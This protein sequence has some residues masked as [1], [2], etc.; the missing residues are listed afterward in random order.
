[1]PSDDKELLY[2]EQDVA[3][4]PSVVGNFIKLGLAATLGFTAYH[5]GL[6]RPIIEEM[7]S[8]AD[9][10]AAEGTNKAGTAM[11]TIKEWTK[12][13]H[14]T[15]AQIRNL[16]KDLPIIPE[17]SIFRVKPTDFLYDVVED[18][19]KM[20]SSGNVDYY[21]VKK[22]LA[23]SLDDLNILHSMIDKNVG[24]IVKA[25]NSFVDT[26]L[27]S[28]IREY[29]RFSDIATYAYRDYRGAAF[30][31]RRKYADEFVDAL[32]L[33]D[34]AAK[35]E[36]FH[37]GFHRARLK[38]FLTFDEAE[39]RLKLKTP[40]GHFSGM[41]DYDYKTGTIAIDKL[42]KFFDEGMNRYH[43]KT[44]WQSGAWE[45]LVLDPAIQISESGRVIDY[46][47]TKKQGIDFIHSLSGDFGLP[48][49]KFNLLKML[50]ADKAFRHKPFGAV[51]APGQ[52][53]PSFTGRAGEYSVG[54]FMG[55][56]LGDEYSKMAVSVI[57]GKAY[58]P[59]KNK[60]GH[61]VLQEFEGKF[62]LH[63]VTHADT[64]MHLENVVNAE[65]QMANLHLA[66][67]AR[68]P[69]EEY[70]KV[71][72]EAGVPENKLTEYKIR[73]KIGDLLDI[74][75]QEMFKKQEFGDAAFRM[76][77]VNP[78][79]FIDDMIAKV[80][81]SKL[82]QTTGFEYGSYDSMM[83][84]ISAGI[85]HKSILGQGFS[86]FKTGDNTIN[87]GMY[88]MSRKGLTIADI[89]EA[90]NDDGLEKGSEKIGDYVAQFFAGRDLVNPGYMTK[91]FNEKST[92]LWG[93]LNK[94]SE[95]IGASSHLLGL[96]VESKGSV[97]QLLGNLLLKRALP[98]Y[99]AFQIPGM[100]NWASE[101]FFGTDENGNPRN[102]GQA[103][104]GGPVKSFDLMAHK[105][106][107]LTM[108]T[109]VFKELGK[110]TP[111][112]DQLNEDIPFIYAM[113]LGQTEEERREYIEKGYDPVRKGRFWGTG[114]TPW[115][116]GKIMYW[117]PNIYRRVE[118]DVQFSDS[119]WGSRQ[120]YYNNAWFPNPVN[121]F[122]PIRHFI[123]DRYHYEEKHYQD[124]PYMITSPEGEN[125]PVIGP[126]FAQTIGRVIKPPRRMH[127]EYW[128]N[129]VVNPADEAPSQLIT[130]TDVPY[131]EPVTPG[132]SLEYVAEMFRRQQESSQ[133][134]V[135]I[136]Q[137]AATTW[138][139]LTNRQIKAQQRYKD[140]LYTSAY[141]AREMVSK[142]TVM[143]DAGVEYTKRTF[144]P[145][146]DYD[147]YGHPYEAYV[148]PSGGISIVDVP[149]EMNIY[150]INKDLR[151]WSINR[152]MGTDQRVDVI[153]EYNNPDLPV[154]N[155]SPQIDNA[156]ITGMGEE[157]NALTD[158]AGLRGFGVRQFITGS[159]NENA[160]I[161][162][163]SG[164]A[165]SAKR[166]FWD[167][168]LGG[169]GGNISEISRRFMQK[170]NN[171]IDYINPVRNTMPS[172]MPG[173]DYFV[174]DFLHGD[175]YAKVE[176]GE[177]RLPGEGYERMYNLENRFKMNIGSSSIGYSKEDIIKHLLG[178]EGYMSGF[179][180]DTLETGTEIHEQ[181]EKLWKDTGFAVSTE[182][183][184]VDNDNGIIGYYDALVHDRSSKT[185]LAIV[186]IKTTSAKKLDEIRK[187]GKPL[188]HHMRQVNYYLWA[189]RN[190]ES[191]GY[192]YYVDKEN[193]ENNYMVGF[194]YSQARLKDT[195]KNVKDARDEIRDAMSRGEI[196]RGDL[197]R[198]IDRLRILADVA[199]Y[200]QEFRDAKA[201]L[202]Q[203]QI[204]QATRD[205]MSAINKRVTEQKEP[206]RVYDYKFSTSNLTTEVVTVKEVIDNDM[207]KTVEY[208]DKHSVQ[209]AG[210]RPSKAKG[211]YYKDTDKTMWQ[212]TNDEIR[213]YIKPGSKIVIQYDADERNKFKKNST[214]SIN[215]VIS[216]RG[217]NVNRRLLEKGMA[218]EK[219]TDNS[220]AGVHV[221]YTNGEIAF[222]AA[223]ERL[224]HLAGRTPFINKIIQVR[225]P[226]EQ[227]KNKEVYGKD[228]QSWNNPIT[229]ILIPTIEKDIGNEGLGGV[230][231]LMLGTYMGSLFGRNKFG[232]IIGGATGFSLV[233]TGKVLKTLG[234]TEE[235]NWVPRRRRKQ[236]ELNEYLDAL[237]YVKNIR[238][239]GEYSNKAKQEDNFDVESYIAGKE[240]KGERNKE[241]IRELEDYK[242]I[243]KLDF[244]HRGR[245][246]FD[247]GAP[248]YATRDMGYKDTIYNINK[249]IREL[250][251]DRKIE[252]LPL[253]AIKAIQF[254]QEAEKTMYGF[255]P[256]DSL[257]NIMSAL[258][259][260][261]RQY[262]K[263]FM[264]APEEEKDKILRI[265]PSYLRRALQAS[266]GL[267]VD[268]KPDLATYFTQHALPGAD[269]V[270][271]NEETDMDALKVKL[272]HASKLD[273]G[274]FDIWQNNK[275]AADQVNI[276]IPNINATHTRQE[277][278][279]KLNSLFKNSG[280]TDV[281]FR[282]VM[283]GRPST[284]ID[285]DEDAR[286]DVEYQIQNLNLG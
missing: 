274:E 131:T 94:L 162:E 197:Y 263:H 175:P 118:A 114:G 261:E 252:K 245:Y 262:F 205:E 119:K 30:N 221:R 22:V 211:E 26:D 43:G 247:Y 246:N 99:M 276:P 181:I 251:N 215:A 199:P 237:K 18:T 53:A 116:G 49:V 127:M 16:K 135:A 210:I 125:I 258:P 242:R 230:A 14:M 11:T 208:G 191:K 212:A 112:S 24:N 170:R 96:S 173:N 280:F 3:G 267:T 225:S 93:V 275:Q 213:K 228:F 42:N 232:R 286:D 227:Y 217:V 90:I 206:L 239:Y 105:I 44:F 86:E 222:G 117:R 277:V 106:M 231:G 15:A 202:A 10:I 188:E 264:D 236:E 250:Q 79:S 150:N 177:E 186:D 279:Y 70:K 59:V 69:W 273:P 235:R 249:E 17:R 284:I 80:T 283:N 224:T 33:T 189:T 128:A 72:L 39:G 78:D 71:L 102:V 178:Q 92:Y 152:V 233:A 32:S 27:F 107:D 50:G 254:K 51:I 214:Q 104:M 259:K 278:Y 253:N 220:P 121:P 146:R 63:D 62:N 20:I 91:N 97:G 130:G 134:Q 155:D 281:Q 241:R 164:Y 209:F 172:W 67:P 5:Q 265:A 48:A 219:E 260:K 75:H 269:W 256:G 176:N 167:Q 218:T 25:R 184:I 74:G 73:Y 28:R 8:V 268:E 132:I 244:S 223:M 139:E 229:G 95:G 68:M 115:S 82:L 41:Q 55:D 120:E 9:K 243:V 124:R 194:D 45:N 180:E 60:A 148:T 282:S 21:N 126:A 136:R 204:D 2:D 110:L 84:S 158:V 144:L 207:I 285:L 257:V 76:D 98:V 138:E 89:F 109:S 77:D 234:T 122:A 103:L 161:I 141:Q 166:S 65:R 169:L 145:Q 159:M 185:G 66:Q 272:V 88:Y 12:L 174:Q 226:Y 101:P 153:N 108:V 240:G 40:D 183:K 238:L 31:L 129:P 7:F 38:D 203:S 151:R 64:F 133:E 198:P 36:Q 156:F 143:D 149:D 140:V 56:M 46:R 147:R 113:G 160:S 6:L 57:G 216:S 201:E 58:A 23:D 61:Y 100:I 248:K 200:S 142:K 52:F 182:G 1:M 196:S 179:E 34:E 13:K 187:S 37:T 271:W 165:Y 111:G 87:P 83:D 54:Q 193:L 190:T 168:N 47:M 154:G 171:N 123:T 4:G 266:W 157:W 255:N 19:R 85:N 163:G 35:R 270:G 137:E 81:K 192:I 195:L 29:E